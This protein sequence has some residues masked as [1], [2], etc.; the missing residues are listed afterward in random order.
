MEVALGIAIGVSTI[1]TL[2]IVGVAYVWMG[3][4]EDEYWKKHKEQTTKR[5]RGN[6]VAVWRVIPE[7]ADNDLNG[8]EQRAD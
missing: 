6:G 7:E 1:E 4:P 5:L 8:R 2:L 3:A